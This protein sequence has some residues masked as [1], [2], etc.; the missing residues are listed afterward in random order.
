MVVIGIDCV[1]PKA[2]ARIKIY[3]D[4]QYNTWEAVQQHITLGGKLR[5][6]TTL[7]GLAIL[8]NM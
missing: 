5:D 3:I 7:E 8:R 2:G 1:S 6:E 4:P